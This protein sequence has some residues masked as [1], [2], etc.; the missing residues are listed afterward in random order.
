MIGSLED[1]RF[2]RQPV[3]TIAHLGHRRTDAGIQ[4]A[5]IQNQNQ[6]KSTNPNASGNQKNA[7]RFNFEMKLKRQSVAS[8]EKCFF[9]LAGLIYETFL[10]IAPANGGSVMLI[11]HWRP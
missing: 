10:K 9:Q 7:A 5:N 2:G 4:T 11:D 1:S 3:W 6:T 8:F